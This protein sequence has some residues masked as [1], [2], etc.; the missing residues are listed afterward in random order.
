MIDRQL[1]WSDPAIA[2]LME[3]FVPCADEVWQLQHKDTP[4]ARLFRSFMDGDHYAPRKGDGRTRQGIYAVAPSGR[5]LASW[6]VRREEIVARN[7]E[8]ALEAWEALAPAER[9]PDVPLEAG[10]RPEDAYPEDGL[11]LRVYTRDLPR[12][13]APDGWRGK[14]WNMDHLWLSREEAAALAA[15]TLPERAARR[16]ARVHG[17]D[18][19]RG[20]TTTY[21]DRAVEAAR[22]VSRVLRRDGEVLYLELSG[23]LAVAEEGVWSIDDRFDEAAPHSRSYRATLF[24]HATWDGE[25]FTEFRLVGAGLRTGATK[26]NERADDPGPAG[27][28]VAFVL[29]PEDDRVA[30]SHFGAYGW[31]VPPRPAAPPGGPSK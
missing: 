8:R 22:L 10:G 11:A 20:Q 7:L 29:A 31:R 19:A 21:P 6:N 16:I 4:E 17:R 30:P 3:R 28:G 15:G 14:A 9:Y 1:A 5:I 2:A 25:R 27:L 18:N 23:E 26:Y 24:G 13:D 12:A